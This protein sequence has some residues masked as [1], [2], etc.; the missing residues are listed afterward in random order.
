MQY[1]YDNLSYDDKVQQYASASPDRSPNARG[2]FILPDTVDK[3]YR[4]M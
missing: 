4:I 2:P 1:F 3:L